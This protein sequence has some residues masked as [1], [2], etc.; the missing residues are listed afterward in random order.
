MRWRRD[1]SSICKKPVDPDELVS[2]ML[3]LA[4]MPRHGYQMQ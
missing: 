4:N 3:T 1:T 2:A